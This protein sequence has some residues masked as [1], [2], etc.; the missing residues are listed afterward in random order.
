MKLE[1][2]GQKYTMCQGAVLSMENTKSK[3]I[4]S[5]VER[6]DKWNKGSNRG[7]VARVHYEACGPGNH[8]FIHLKT[9]V[10]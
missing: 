1:G 9:G 7:L 6:K 5:P 2:Y 4:S 3:E 10:S 8:Y